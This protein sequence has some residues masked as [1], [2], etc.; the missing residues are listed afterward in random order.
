MSIG[1]NHLFGKYTS[2]SA[3]LDATQRLIKMGGRTT[4]DKVTGVETVRESMCVSVPILTLTNEQVVSIHKHVEA[5]CHDVQKKI[6][7][8]LR[9]KGISSVNDEQ[10]SFAAIVEYL[11]SDAEGGR[12]DKEAVA[13]WFDSS[14]KENLS[15]ALQMVLKIDS[16]ETTSDEKKVQLQQAMNRYRECYM[17][18]AGGKKSYDADTAKKLLDKLAECADENDDI[19]NKFA[20]RLEKMTVKMEDLI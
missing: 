14:L 15:V 11:D 18:L 8:E 16:L 13:K 7:V 5:M 6:C 2:K 10:I 20:A 1:T 3:P 4:K 9:D 19:A 17:S 12:L